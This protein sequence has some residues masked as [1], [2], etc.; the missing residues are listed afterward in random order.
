MAD[1]AWKG[2]QSHNG[3]L[4]LGR[5]RARRRLPLPVSSSASPPPERAPAKPRGRKDGGGGASS[6]P[7]CA[8]RPGELSMAVAVVARSAP[9]SQYLAGGWPAAGAD[10]GGGGAGGGCGG[11]GAGGGYGGEGDGDDDGGPR[12]WPGLSRT[13]PPRDLRRSGLI[14]APSTTSTTRTARCTSRSE[15]P[16]PDLAGWQLATV[17]DGDGGGCGDG[18]WRRWRLW[19]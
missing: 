9:C 3:E 5:R 17:A 14:D 19:R 1:H 10:G 11:G 15:P 7:R 2:E 13:S 12:R 6:H 16:R 4:E 18:G 8:R